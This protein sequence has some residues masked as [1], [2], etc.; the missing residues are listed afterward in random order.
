MLFLGPCSKKINVC[1]VLHFPHP[2]LCYAMLLLQGT[3]PVR[4]EIIHHLNAGD[5]TQNL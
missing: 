1:I 3:F 5:A 4:K 2:G